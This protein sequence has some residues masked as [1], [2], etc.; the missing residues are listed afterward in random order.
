MSTSGPL[1]YWF[2]FVKFHE[3]TMPPSTPTPRT[4]IKAKTV[5]IYYYCV[6]KILSMGFVYVTHWVYTLTHI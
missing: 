5:N 3:M 1:P 4:P 6:N 2:L